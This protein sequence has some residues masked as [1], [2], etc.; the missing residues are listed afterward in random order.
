[1]QQGVPVRAVIPALEV[2]RDAHRRTVA[3]VTCVEIRAEAPI[4]LLRE[5]RRLLRVDVL[6]SGLI[7]VEVV[8]GRERFE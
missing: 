3:G 5:L 8:V 4:H 2:K 1:V 7:Q 6:G